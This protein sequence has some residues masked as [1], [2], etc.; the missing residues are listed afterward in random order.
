MIQPLRHL[1]ALLVASTAFASAT[2][3]LEIRNP[4]ERYV[5]TQGDEISWE[6][7]TD[8]SP[9][10]HA[11]RYTLKQ[12]GGIL[13]REGTLTFTDGAATLNTTA[14][15]P[16]ILFLEVE[17]ARTDQPPLTASAGAVVDPDK[18]VRS[19]PRP[20]DFDAFWDGHLEALGQIP[21]NPVLTS[22]PSEA[23]GV[24]YWKVTLDHL[25]GGKIQAQLARPEMGETFPALV[26]FQ[27]AG[28][29]G[30]PQTNVTRRAEAG[31]L[32][33]NVMAHDLPLDESPDFYQEQ[34]DG[35]LRAYVQIGRE[36]RETSYFL[37]MLLATSRAVDYVASRPDWDGRTLVV[38]GNSQ[39]GLQAVAAAALNPQ[40]TA[41]I[42]NV[43]AGCD[44]TAPLV[45]R[46][47]SWPYWLG[48]TQGEER[49][50]ITQTSSYFD[51]VNFAP[52]VTCPVLAAFG[53]LDQSATA[54]SNYLL[55]RHLGGPVEPLLLP[56]AEHQNKGGT[57]GPF[58]RRSQEWL[59]SLVSG[60]GRPEF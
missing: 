15:K 38:L 50:R 6:I 47:M 16:G 17:A 22:N 23:A 29:Y 58:Y 20:D 5:F 44:T 7:A 39:G 42:M 3:A 11:V 52:R 57:H 49:E 59:D 33:L 32:T 19:A 37:R 1:F 4:A 48:Q 55:V 51:A 53:L 8:Q 21:L 13:L 46:R 54:S 56:W 30:L 12:D 9:H 60:T 18:I 10:P 14:S 41:A 36:D 43:T 31:W 2:L 27:Y 26:V 45:G 28:V 40:V 24:S 35:P 25:A 34:R